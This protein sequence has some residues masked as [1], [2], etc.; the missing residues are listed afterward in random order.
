MLT[1]IIDYFKVNRTYLTGAFCKLA[2]ILWVLQVAAGSRKWILSTYPTHS[3]IY[4][5]AAILLMRF[6]STIITATFVASISIITAVAVGSRLARRAGQ[7]LA[8]YVRSSQY[9]EQEIV[10]LERTRIINRQ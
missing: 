9:R 10:Q 5:I 4:W 2:A 3:V 8:V 6:V 7:P 1:V